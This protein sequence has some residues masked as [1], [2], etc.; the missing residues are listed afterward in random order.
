L[1]CVPEKRE[2]FWQAVAQALEYAQLLKPE[3]INILPGRC[4]D[5]H[6][7]KEN[8]D[9]EKSLLRQLQIFLIQALMIL[10]M[11]G[12][13]IDAIDRTNLDTLR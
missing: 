4:L 9:T 1:A 13:F 8:L 10:N 12:I 5:C 3:V 2:Q 11:H 6:R 7:Q